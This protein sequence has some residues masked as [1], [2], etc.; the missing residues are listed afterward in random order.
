MLE[1]AFYPDEELD[2]ETREM[3]DAFRQDLRRVAVGI[4]GLEL[5][6]KDAHPF[7]Q[8]T[9]PYSRIPGKNIS[10][11]FNAHL[12]PNLEESAES[13]RLV[14]SALTALWEETASVLRRYN[15]QASI[16]PIAGKNFRAVINWANWSSVFLRQR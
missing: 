14:E 5:G 16:D 4:Q 15:P 12:P 3:R 9:L 6:F 2:A 8:D 10:Q 13:V 7:P 1:L 11:N